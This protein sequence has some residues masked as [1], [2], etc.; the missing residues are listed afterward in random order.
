MFQNKMR[1]IKKVVAFKKRLFKTKMTSPFEIPQKQASKYARSLIE[2]LRVSEEDLQNINV[3]LEVRSA[4]D[5]IGSQNRFRSLFDNAPQCMLVVDLKSQKI[6]NANKSAVAL[7]KYSID[8][9]FKLG[10][11]ELSPEWQPDGIASDTRIGADIE[12]L[13]EGK[14]VSIEWVY[15]DAHGDEIQ[16][17]L[18]INLLSDTDMSQ[19]I[20]NI[21]DVTEKNRINEKLKLQLDELKKTN[22]ELDR[23]V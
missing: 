12:K 19:V 11:R 3:E 22:S 1:L 9:L 18:S 5:L 7:F 21:I 23:F 20:V 6:I 13:L 16:A 15:N 17:E 10:P 14:K 4:K 2:A 8:D